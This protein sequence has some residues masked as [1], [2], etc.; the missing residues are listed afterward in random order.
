MVFK[1][2]SNDS[3]MMFIWI[4]CNLPSGY[5]SMKVKGKVQTF[6]RPA[7]RSG[8]CSI[9]KSH[10]AMGANISII[11]IYLLFC[12]VNPTNLVGYNDYL[13]FLMIQ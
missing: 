5:R 7:A 10:V 4:D 3:I 13:I 8:F 1:I 12:S 11:L 9:K 2:T 6:A